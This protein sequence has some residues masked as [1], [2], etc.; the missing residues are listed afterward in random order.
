MLEGNNITLPTAPAKSGSTFS[1]W[2]GFPVDGK[3]FRFKQDTS[4]SNK[5]VA[6]VTFHAAFDKTLRKLSLYSEG[7]LYYQCNIAEGYG[8]AQYMPDAPH[9]TGYKFRAW[10]SD[11][12]LGS[13]DKMPANDVTANALFDQETYWVKYLNGTDVYALQSYAYGQQVTLPSAPSKSSYTFVYWDVDISTMP[14]IWRSSSSSMYYDSIDETIRL[15][16]V[17]RKIQ[18]Q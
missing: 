8:I 1:G 15:T 6:T 9:K 11:T 10:D 5:S 4:D 13:S 7:N 18:V 14:A 3:M 2:S 12:S 17:W 16:A